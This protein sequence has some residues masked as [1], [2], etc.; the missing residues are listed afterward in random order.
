ML[1]ESGPN[2]SEERRR[3][4]QILTVRRRLAQFIVLDETSPNSSEE[5]RRNK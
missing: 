1:V 4:K 5:R 3:D 2:S